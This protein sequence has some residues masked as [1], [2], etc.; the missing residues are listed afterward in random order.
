MRNRKPGDATRSCVYEV[1]S[2]S[3]IIKLDTQ[4][5]NALLGC[6]HESVPVH[7]VL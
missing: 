3:L 5:L 4:L 7:A 1:I 6:M 2:L